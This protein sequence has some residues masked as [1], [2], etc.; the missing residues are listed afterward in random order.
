M[1]L[2]LP[3][4]QASQV[5][6]GGK[7]RPPG[8]V[9]MMPSWWPGPA[10]CWRRCWRA[11]GPSVRGS[12]AREDGLEPVCLVAACLP[13]STF[14]SLVILLVMARFASYLPPGR[15]NCGARGVIRVRDWASVAPSPTP[16]LSPRT[17][18]FRGS[19]HKPWEPWASSWEQVWAVS[20][21][22]WA[23]GWL[24]GPGLLGRDR[25]LWTAGAFPDSVPHVRG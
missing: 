25:G 7:P 22:A 10:Q 8:L 20:A 3:L 18:S 17:R 16:P 13:L 6:P 24:C 2:L 5:C 19:S 9:A 14:P 15:R 11:G 12:A 21:C 4:R 23:C 1:R